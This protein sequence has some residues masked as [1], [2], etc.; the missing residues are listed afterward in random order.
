M[1][2]LGPQPPISPVRSARVQRR[3]KRLPAA[4]W[5]H[6]IATSRLAENDLFGR[7]R[8]RTF[9]A[10]DELPEANALQLI[11]TYQPGGK[12]SSDAERDAAREIVRLLGRITLAVETAAVFLGQLRLT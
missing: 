3:A 4:D 8:D 5:L 12:F 7:H 2:P 11:E 1:G 9:L 10:V 6:I